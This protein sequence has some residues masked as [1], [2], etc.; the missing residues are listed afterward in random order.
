MK[1]SHNVIKMKLNLNKTFFLTNNFK[2]FI[3]NVGKI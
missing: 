2:E 1:L 3:V